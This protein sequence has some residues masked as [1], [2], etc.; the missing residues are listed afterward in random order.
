MLGPHARLGIVPLGA[1]N[2][3]EQDGVALFAHREVLIA[4]GDAELVNR[5]AANRRLFELEGQ[6]EAL[7]RHLQYLH[8]LTA[9]LG[10]DPVPG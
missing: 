5:G 2:R 9:N 3:A 7:P 1:A 6:A 4:E 10:A 8:G